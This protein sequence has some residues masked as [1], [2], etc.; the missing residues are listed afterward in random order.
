MTERLLHLLGGKGFNREMCEQLKKN[1]IC[2]ILGPGTEIPSETEAENPASAAS[3]GAVGSGEG[4]R[5]SAAAQ[6]AAPRGPGPETEVGEVDGGRG[7]E[8]GV[9]DVASIVASG[10]TS[11]FLAQKEK[12]KE[13]RAAKAR[14]KKAALAEAAAADKKA[15]LPNSQKPKVSFY[16]HERKALA[17]LA[18]TNG[19]HPPSADHSLGEGGA[20]DGAIGQEG[21]GNAAIAAGPEKA[22]SG[23]GSNGTVFVRKE[24]EVG[25]ERFEAASDD[26][27]RTIADAVHRAILSVPEISKRSELWDS[28]IIVGNGSKVRGEYIEWIKSLC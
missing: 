8:D 5:N 24:I 19:S 16:Y 15:K 12:E 14:D 13:D 20:A 10:K 17:D 3:T 26:A 7:E 2:E 22:D 9:L 25:R 4:Q 27:L 28:L 11:E 21:D 23:Q 1:A 18:S 6:G